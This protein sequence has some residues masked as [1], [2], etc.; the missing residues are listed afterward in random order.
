MRMEAWPLMLALTTA[1]DAQTAGGWSSANLTSDSVQSYYA[2][3]SL[4]SNYA[5]TVL[6]YVCAT[7]F[8]S[9]EQQVVAGVNYRFHVQGCVAPSLSA[10]NANCTCNSTQQYVVTVFDQPWAKIHQILNIT[11]E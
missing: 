2:A 10:T 11:T 8:T 4:P 7:S 3:V 9:L 1:V 6:P 5:G